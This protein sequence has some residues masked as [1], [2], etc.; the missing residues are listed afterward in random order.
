MKNKKYNT[1]PCD[2]CKHFRTNKNA[3]VNTGSDTDVPGLLRVVTTSR[4]WQRPDVACVAIL[5]ALWWVG[6]YL[7]GPAGSIPLGD[8]WSF[9]KAAFRLANGE[10]YNP[11]D[12]AAMTLIVHALWGAMFAKLFG[13]DFAALRAGMLVLGAVCGLVLW[14]GLRR[15]GTARWT[16]LIAV[17][18]LMLNPLYFALSHSFMTDVTFLTLLVVQ[19][20]CL[21]KC[22][23]D[24]S[25]RWIAWSALATMLSALTRDPGVIPAL[26]MAVLVFAERKPGP[27][28]RSAL[29]FA[30][31]VIALLGFRLWARHAGID[32]SHSDFFRDRFIFD[33]KALKWVAWIG[34]IDSVLMYI[35]FFSLPLLIPVG[36][37]L[38]RERGPVR[39]W[40]IAGF[41]AGLAFLGGWYAFMGNNHFPPE[42][43]WMDEAGFVGAPLLYDT[44]ILHQS[45]VPRVPHWMVDAATAAS[46]AG[47]A[48][49][50]ASFAAIGWLPL[51]KRRWAIFCAVSM[52]AVNA[53]WFVTDL[54][55]DRY[56][57]PGVIFALMMCC[58]ILSERPAPRWT[59]APGVTLVLLFAL[60]SVAAVHD[61]IEWQRAR[62]V[63]LDYL[64]KELGVPASRI[65][66]GFEF[67]GWYAEKHPIPFV[68]YAF[69]GDGPPIPT[70]RSWWW[71]VDAEYMVAFGPVDGYRTIATFPYVR[72]MPGRSNWAIYVLRRAGQ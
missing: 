23:E 69:T 52:V 32:L 12:W 9:A 20:F 29:P 18:T 65:D 11:P 43:G 46:I 17:A 10:G 51:R 15:A 3:I 54:Y 35:G 50:I 2:F 44:Y 63:G 1:P 39:H 56:A 31:G 66:G 25:W 7:T 22:A 19:A 27:V 47:G 40:A 62:W 41:I 21:M 71:V 68:E 14:A 33:L 24:L 45:D 64:T 57:L 16:A 8:D 28:W 61:F 60:W 72:W 26:V 38:L 48:L 59:S 13:L 34:K 6:V 42:G 36:A 30:C 55:F 37:R 4:Q 58:F 5:M 53:Q 67:N 49:L 70:D